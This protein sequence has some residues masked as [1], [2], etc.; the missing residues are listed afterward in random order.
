MNTLNWY[1]K[2]EGAGYFRREWL[3]E[4]LE[5]PYP[6]DEIKARVRCFDLASSVPTEAN[7][8]PD[9]TVGVLIAK[10]KSGIYVI[11]DMVRF[12]KRA[13]EVEQAVIDII[14][15]DRD[16]FGS[17]YTGYLPVDPAAAG[18]T[19]KIYYSKLFAERGVP[20]RFAK[21]GTKNSKLKRFEPF[22]ASSEN[23]LVRILKADWNEEFFYELEAFDGTRKKIHDDIVDSVSDGFNILA[24][25]KELPQVNAKLLKMS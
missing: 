11:E 24:T 15:K 7:P 17:K 23:E 12:R 4:P 2:E 5:H 8:D 18:K 3:F 6:E 19:T 22:S 14:E 16:M 21:V 13:G 25:K 20:V 10:T 9:Y 1:A